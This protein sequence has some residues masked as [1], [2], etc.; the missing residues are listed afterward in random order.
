MSSRRTLGSAAAAAVIA[1]LALPGAAGAAAGKRTFSQVYPIASHLCTEVSAGA[2]PKRL[3]HSAAQVIADCTLLQGNFNTAR[4]TVLATHAALLA[5]GAA[6]R[7]ALAVHCTGAGKVRLACDRAHDK[8]RA[9]LNGLSHQRVR[10]AHI[11][12]ESIET[13]RKA[14]WGAIRALPGG[15]G[16]RE[17]QRIRVQDS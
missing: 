16:V 7:A 13:S 12:Y 3:R 11:Y 9:L 1:T 10:A 15:K 17:D 8:D 14:F 4:A 5:E 2:G 6:A